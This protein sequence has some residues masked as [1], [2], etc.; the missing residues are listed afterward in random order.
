MHEKKFKG[1]DDIHC[2]QSWKEQTMERSK[3]YKRNKAVYVWRLAV[4]LL[5]ILLT[6]GTVYACNDTIRE[7]LSSLFTDEQEQAQVREDPVSVQMLGAITYLDADCR[8]YVKLS[9]EQ[10]VTAD[11]FTVYEKGRIIG[12]D[13]PQ[14]SK[15]LELPAEDG[16]IRVTLQYIRLNNQLLP[17]Y[18][19][20]SEELGMPSSSVTMLT[21]GKLVVEYEQDAFQNACLVDLQTNEVLSIADLSYGY[22][23]AEGSAPHIYA[24]NVKSSASGRF[25]LYR[26]YALA[27]G[28][29]EDKTKAQWV[30]LDS[31]QGTRRVLDTEKL[32]GYLLGNELHMAGNDK[33]ITTKSYAVDDSTSAD[34]PIVYDYRK[35]T[36]TEYRDYQ[37]AVP[38]VSDFLYRMKESAVE[39]LDVTTQE[40][41][42]IPLP[43]NT[44]P[45]DCILCP[46][47]GFYIS[48]NTASNALDIY[49]VS[50]Q[51]WVHLDQDAFGDGTSL[52]FAYPL[53]DHTLSL[54][55]N[56]LIE[57][58]K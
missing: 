48:E 23:A 30:L 4:V 47:A 50:Q 32:P 17:L 11:T 28:W 9:E 36:W 22:A 6:F 58:H 2:P 21:D 27:Q 8:Y 29:A 5:L 16:T 45:Q 31:E 52:L 1:F 54:N 25:L 38:F 35:D 55:Q 57:F 20:G 13:I 41:Q 46:Y 43:D 53:D 44:R 14:E 24:T 40:K 42:T 15:E 39:L 37:C 26:S 33:I 7:W 10:T 56:Y 34:Y 3:P 18:L 19:K 49:V 12:K 51:R